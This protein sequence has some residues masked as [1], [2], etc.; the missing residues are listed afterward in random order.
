MPIARSIIGS[1]IRIGDEQAD[2]WSLTAIVE[3]KKTKWRQHR[4]FLDRAD[5]HEL[6]AYLL[7]H[8]E[9]CEDAI[10]LNS[11]ALDLDPG[12]ADL[13]AFLGIALEGVLHRRKSR[14]SAGIGRS[15]SIP[16]SRQPSAP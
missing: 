7:A 1:L 10:R 11:R 5:E 13:W 12:N 15:P 14:C 6:Q 4:A 8:Q 2:R 3:E 9:R 16:H